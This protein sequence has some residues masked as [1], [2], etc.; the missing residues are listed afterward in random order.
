MLAY[1]THLEP[2]LSHAALRLLGHLN[3]KW[4]SS[5]TVTPRTISP[6]AG[7]DDNAEFVDM[8]QS[9]NDNG[10]I[11]YEAFLIDS[12]SGMRFIETIITPRGKATF[13]TSE[14]LASL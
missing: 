9:L 6:A 12:S 10:M 1:T 14:A 5:A 7:S 4:P 2:E 13:R 11:S 3:Q 8:V